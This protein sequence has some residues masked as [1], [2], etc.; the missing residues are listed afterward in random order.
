LALISHYQPFLPE[1]RRGRAV[2]E[3]CDK[4]NLVVTV[5]ASSPTTFF[6]AAFIRLVILADDHKTVLLSILATLVA[7]CL[8]FV[9]TVAIAGGVSM[10][11]FKS[12]VLPLFMSAFTLA[13]FWVFLFARNR[14][15]L[16]M[17]A[18]KAPRRDEKASTA[19]E[20]TA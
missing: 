1:N 10:A 16:P 3:R 20:S 14:G 9:T 2:S 18:E 6:K 4:L 7:A 5:G 8:L 17:L 15:K 13:I 19:P 11:L 12:Y